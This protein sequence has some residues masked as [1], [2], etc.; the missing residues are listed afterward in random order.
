MTEEFEDPNLIENADHK[1]LP[2][3]S[4]LLQEKW[5]ERR[6]T[7]LILR[8]LA[9]NLTNFNQEMMSKIRNLIK[10]VCVENEKVPRPPNLL[11][12]DKN[13]DE[14]HRLLELDENYGKAFRVPFCVKFE[15]GQRS[16]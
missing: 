16:L 6:E 1:S 14:G 7:C 10:A 2:S 4:I 3:I 15:D 13:F 5:S 9:T 12:D 8:E 11:K